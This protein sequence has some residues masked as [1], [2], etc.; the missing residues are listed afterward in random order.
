[1]AAEL[2]ADMQY[3]EEMIKEVEKEEDMSL[4]E[5]LKESV[6]EM[7]EDIKDAT[8]NF[9]EGLKEGAQS[10]KKTAKTVASHADE[11]SHDIVSG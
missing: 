9:A 4:V 1:M 10:L 11:I 3:Q 6:K 7:K 5:N 2:P 8:H